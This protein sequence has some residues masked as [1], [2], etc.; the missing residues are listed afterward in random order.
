[1][2][3]RPE[4]RRLDFIRDGPNAQRRWRN[5]GLKEEFKM[6]SRPDHTAAPSGSSAHLQGPWRRK[7][8][9]PRECRRTTNEQER[10]AWDRLHRLEKSMTLRDCGV[11]H[12]GSTSTS[13]SE[14]ER[15]TAVAK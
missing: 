9:P 1:M 10:T 7:R 8:A 2:S 13:L 15:T 11:D 4:N 12:G 6:R 14:L 3:G 5:R